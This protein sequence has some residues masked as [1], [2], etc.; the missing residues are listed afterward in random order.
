[1]CVGRSQKGRKK[2]SRLFTRCAGNRA[3]TRY[4]VLESKSF[5]EKNEKKKRY[6]KKS[7]ENSTELLPHRVDGWM[8]LMCFG[9]EL[10]RDLDFGRCKFT[11]TNFDPKTLQIF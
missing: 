10:F 3:E 11:S 1:M 5:G 9:V 8:L 7:A 4:C 6:R 2:Y